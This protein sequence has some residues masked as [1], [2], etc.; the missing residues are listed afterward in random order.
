MGEIV[1][2]AGVYTFS[3]DNTDGFM[4]Y[5]GEYQKNKFHGKGILKMKD[6]SVYRGLFKGGLR[7]G[8]GELTVND[9]IIFK[10]GYENGLKEGKCDE[11]SI[12]GGTISRNSYKSGKITK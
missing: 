12:D 1:S 6:G 9:K 5:T 2:N 11:G 7:H 3:V 10:G 8:K 4:T